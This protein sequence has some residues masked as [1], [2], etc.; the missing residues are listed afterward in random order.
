VR[1]RHHKTGEKVVK[2][3]SL[4]DKTGQEPSLAMEGTTT[5][6]IQP[7]TWNRFAAVSALTA[8]T[9]HG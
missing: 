9:L 3:S 4:I 7:F 1:A 5:F 6:P 2:R 8:A